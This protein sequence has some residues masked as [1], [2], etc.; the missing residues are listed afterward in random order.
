M[1]CKY[2]CKYTTKKQ[3]IFNYKIYFM[4]FFGGKD[5]VNLLKKLD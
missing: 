5:I 1:F 4:K 3:V 2:I